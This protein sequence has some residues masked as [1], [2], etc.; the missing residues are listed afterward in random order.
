M[1][2]SSVNFD[3]AAAVY[4][5]TRGFPAETERELA[6]IL[7]AELRDR[8]SCLE[9]GVGTGRMAIPLRR[10]GVDMYGVDISLAMLTELLRKRSGGPLPWISVADATDLPFENGS[11]GAALA[12]HVLH[13]V[14][15][16]ER[17]ARELVRV[18]RPGG[19]V[20]A[21]LGGA[22]LP[23]MRAIR[24][25]LAVESGRN[26]LDPGISDPDALE[27]LMHSL[28]ARSRLLPPVDRRE[29]TTLA[30]QLEWLGNNGSAAT[31]DLD[32]T[33]RTVAVGRVREWAVQEFGDPET[34][35]VDDA[36]IVFRAYD[37]A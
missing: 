36:P 8:G 35:Y 18:V 32:D 22:D 11:F 10:H 24:L 6:V 20:I 21:G 27:R 26:Q 28:G 25:R 13:L 33:T 12:C 19:V 30:A 31:W 9:I 16:W 34:T 14:G 1:P 2:A 29:R 17:A 5:A 7:A 23:I 4:D 15:D 3:R 37:L